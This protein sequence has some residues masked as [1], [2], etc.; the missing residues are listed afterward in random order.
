M[1]TSRS[2]QQASVACQRW[3]AF[4]RRHAILAGLVVL[5]P[6]LLALFWPSSPVE[7]KRTI[8]P[9]EI[10]AAALPVPEALPAVEQEW[11]RVTVQSGDSLYQIFQRSGLSAGDLAHL[12]NSQEARRLQRI[13]PGESL[14]YQADDAGTLLSLR[15]KADPL[16]TLIFSRDEAQ[17]FHTAIEQHTPEVQV[18]YRQGAIESSLF[19]AGQASGLPQALLMEYADIFSGVVDFALDV[20]RGDRFGLVYEER[21]LHG[22]RVGTGRVLAAYFTNQGQTH[23]AYF[24]QDSQGQPGYFAPDGT[25]MRKAFLRAPLDFTRVSSNFNPRRLHPVFKTVR[26]HNG[27]DYAAPTGTPVYAAGDGRVVQSGFSQANGNYVFVQH[28]DKYVTRYLH[29]HKRLVK[30]GQR[31]RQRQL[32]GQV[33]STGYATGPHLHYEFLVNGVHRNPRTIIDQLPKAVSLSAAEKQRFEVQTSGLRL[34]LAMLQNDMTIAQA[35]TGRHA[36]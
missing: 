24:Y 32:I 4:S 1:K 13:R 27:I 6:V 29:L 34:Q 26:P 3:Q 8:I 22:E 28:G 18:S 21:Y 9:L 36:R 5:A 10:D 19:A 31:V 25:S 7:A 20:R 12:M 30:T 14:E 23:T 35:D 15:Y 17:A 33:G 16:T 11:Q 2:Q